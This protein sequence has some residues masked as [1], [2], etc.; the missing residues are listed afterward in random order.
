MPIVFK[1]N[2]K[3]ITQE[4]RNRQ[5]RNVVKAANHIRNSLIDKVSQPGDG[6]E[7]P[8]RPESGHV[9]KVEITNKLGN[10]QTVQKLMG[11]KMHKAS[12]PG[13]PPATM[14]GGLRNSFQIE[15][16]HEGEAFTGYIGPQNLEYAKALE[17]GF[18]G[19]DKNGKQH[20]LQPR[21]YM[22]PTFF[23]EAETVKKLLGGTGE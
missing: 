23:E 1:S 6:N 21:P 19:K 10:K 3:L 18:V 15:Y 7:Y 13:N 9:D 14:R 8:L 20:N 16:D 17:F 2:I 5:E 4:L 11:A 12:S 22:I